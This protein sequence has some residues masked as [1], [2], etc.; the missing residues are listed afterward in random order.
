MNVNPLTLGLFF[1][2]SCI[3][4]FIP[5][6]YAAIE[7]KTPLI[8]ILFLDNKLPVFHHTDHYHTE[9]SHVR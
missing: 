4:V 2:C 6:L 8:F 1:G 9:V 3:N 5:D 7:N